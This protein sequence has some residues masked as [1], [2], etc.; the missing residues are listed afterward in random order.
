MASENYYIEHKDHKH[1][2]YG[3]IGTTLV[4]GLIFAALFFVVMYPPDPPLELQGIQMSLGEENMGG[5]NNEPVPDP[6]PTEQYTPISEQTEE[7]NLSSESDESVEIKDNKTTK[8]KEIKE[9]KPNVVEEKKPQLELPKKVNQQ[10]LFTKKKNTNQGGYGDGENPGNEGR[11][12]GSPDGDKDGHG[13]GD[14]GF[15]SGETGPDGISYVM[16]K[17]RKVNKLPNIEDNSKSVGKVVVSITVNQDGEVI[18]AIP[19]Q[20]G[21]TTTEPTLLEKA[22]QGALKTKFNPRTDGSED[23]TGTITIVFRFKP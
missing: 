18:K 23:Q 20:I 11:P 22:K 12:D 2:L 6:A 21:S 8:P 17:G 7:T 13:L 3:F 14:S 19:G 16:P 4:H 15:G 9:T 10:A 5:P 1:Q